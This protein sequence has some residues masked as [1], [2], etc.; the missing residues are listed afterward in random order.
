MEFDEL[1]RSF[2]QLKYTKLDKTAAALKFNALAGY[3][4]SVVRL[5]FTYET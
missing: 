4:A 5:L 3:L 1:L 2:A